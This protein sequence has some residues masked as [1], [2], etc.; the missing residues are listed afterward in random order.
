MAWGGCNRVPSKDK[1]QTRSLATV[2]QASYQARDRQNS[3]LLAPV[4]DLTPMCERAC[5]NWID[6][7]FPDPVGL[8]S[9]SGAPRESAD[10]ILTRQRTVNGAMC[11]EACI[12]NGERERVRCVIRAVTLA[13]FQACLTR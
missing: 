10:E 4:N 12:K 13:E 1:V 5:E 11:S 6:V 7:Q 9:I 3:E 8:D 2:L